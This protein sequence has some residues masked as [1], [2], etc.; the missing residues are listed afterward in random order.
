MAM[1]DS[2]DL[3]SEGTDNELVIEETIEIVEESMMPAGKLDPKAVDE[4]SEDEGEVLNIQDVPEEVSL[5]KQFFNLHN[6]SNYNTLC[7]TVKYK[8][9]KMHEI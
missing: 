6:S 8:K 5:S 3:T 9:K 4:S 7:E 2:S 1:L